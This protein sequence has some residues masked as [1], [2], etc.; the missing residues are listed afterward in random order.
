MKRDYTV[1]PLAEEILKSNREFF[2]EEDIGYL[3]DYLVEKCQ[4]V[5]IDRENDIRLEVQARLLRKVRNGIPFNANEQVE[6][7]RYNVKH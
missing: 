7:I 6:A 3:C 4:R 5:V 1:R 2:S